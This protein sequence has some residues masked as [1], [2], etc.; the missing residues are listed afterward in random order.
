MD[1]GCGVCCIFC[2][3]GRTWGVVCGIFLLWM[4]FG[5]CGGN[6]GLVMADGPEITGIV[7]VCGVV[8]VVWS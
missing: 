2:V 3:K 5:S 7:C 8:S 1:I 4:H 6:G